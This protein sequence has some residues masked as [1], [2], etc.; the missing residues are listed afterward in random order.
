MQV[1]LFRLVAGVL[2]LGNVSFVEE[3]T[4]EGTTACISPGQDALEVAAALLGMQKDLLSSA[5]LNKRITRSSSS[6]RNSIYYLKKD[7]RQATYSRDTIAKTVYELVF[8]WLMRR[9]ASALEYNEALRDVL[10]YI[11]V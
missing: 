8:T 4:D 6:R 11:G 9:C 7:I 10:P 2:H 5:M 1:D 3:E